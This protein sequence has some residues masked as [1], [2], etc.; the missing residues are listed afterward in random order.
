M[1][2]EEKEELRK[3]IVFEVPKPYGGQQ[4]GIPTDVI[5][6]CDEIGFSVHV[7]KFRSQMENRK[8]AMLM[9]ELYLDA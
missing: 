5:L 4:C 1:T 8:L 6:K 7:S 9:F 3:L 2:E